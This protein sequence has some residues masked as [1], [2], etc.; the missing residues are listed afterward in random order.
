MR[1]IAGSPAFALGWRFGLALL[2]AAILWLVVTMPPDD[3]ATAMRAPVPDA[4]P[5]PETATGAT[6]PARGAG[7]ADIAA[8]PV[9]FPSRAPWTPPPAPEPEPEEAPP[10]SLASFE[11]VGVIVSGK[12]RL[13]LVKPSGDET[14]T[15]LAL[16]QEFEGWILQDI[17]QEKLHF[18][19]GKTEYDMIFPLH[20]ERGQ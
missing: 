8:H 9:F 19:A 16:G 4:G 17:T 10:P 12:E 14:I 1:A 20:A 13:A 5:L 11:A 18:V 2:G 3:A 7:Y 15:I 6:A